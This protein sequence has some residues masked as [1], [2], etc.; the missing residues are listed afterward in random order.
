M[1]E[2][3]SQTEA[4]PGL[5]ARLDAK[6]RLRVLLVLLF[7]AILSCTAALILYDL[8]RVNR[9]N[10]F[11]TLAA[12]EFDAVE[13][14]L[15]ASNTLLRSFRGL[16]HASTHVTRAE[17]SQF[18]RALDL[19]TGVQAVEWIPWVRAG[20]RNRFEASARADGLKEF[21]ITEMTDQAQPGGL[22]LAAARADYFPVYYLYPMKG[23]RPAIGFDLAS[24][25]VR[26]AALELARDSGRMVATARIKL[27]QETGDQH[28]FLVFVPIYRASDNAVDV[29]RRRQHL[30]GFG[31][32]V[33]RASSLVTAMKAPI[34]VASEQIRVQVY[35]VT[36]A[37]GVKAIHP[38]DAADSFDFVDGLDMSLGRAI[39]MAGRR[40]RLIA[41]P[42]NSPTWAALHWPSV[43]LLLAGLAVSV[44]MAQHLR[45]TLQRTAEVERIVLSRTRSLVEANETLQTAQA[46][47]ELMALY[48]NLTEL[49][50]RKLFHDTLERALSHANR[51]KSKVFLL[52]ADLDRFKEVN[53]SHGHQAGDRVL[54]EVAVRLSKSSRREDLVARIG[55]DEFAVLI[56]HAQAVDDA[57]AMVNKI[58]A[59]FETPVEVDDNSFDIGISIG[60]AVYPDDGGDIETVMQAADLAM[61]EAKSA[62]GGY[63]LAGGGAGR[64][65]VC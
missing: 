15:N 63:R 2:A 59:A 9:K 39:D 18:A 25:P 3:G 11:E 26:R 56:D 7:S 60:V 44:L 58:V 34:R 12:A 48:D 13:R 41:F 31:L 42:V 16:F 51:H 49:A 8:E 10:A 24:D 21:R 6:A 64:T 65:S 33:F 30:L 55:G 62:G 4:D 28:G 54:R 36:D 17:F 35:D 14:R 52:L 47:L 37:G 50:N 45:L 43:L 20:E 29:A 46:Q 22:R 40:W 32:G 1:V 5:P 57:L 19:G 53:D 23:N 61:Y 27:V 38:A